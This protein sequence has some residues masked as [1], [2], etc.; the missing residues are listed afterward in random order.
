VN[1]INV[2]HLKTLEEKSISV[3]RHVAKSAKIAVD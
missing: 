1:G 2:K 3:F